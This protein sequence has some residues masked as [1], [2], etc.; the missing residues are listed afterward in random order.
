MTEKGEFDYFVGYFDRESDFYEPVKVYSTSYIAGWVEKG[1]CKR[2]S[3]RNTVWLTD[4]GKEI[5]NFG[6]L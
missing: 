3:A 4:L 1:W 2:A 6:N 5:I